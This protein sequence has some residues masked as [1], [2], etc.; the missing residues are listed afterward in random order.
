[1]KIAF[2]GG[3]VMA[4]AIIQRAIQTGTLNATDIC[5]VDPVAERRLLFRESLGILITS[6][7]V[8]DL[9]EFPLI[10]VAV[11][12]QQ[13]TTVF[14][15]TRG[16]LSDDHT[17]LSI[18]AGA[19]I[20][21]LSRGFDLP[22]I[23]RVMPNTPSQIGLGVSVW[24]A[25]REVS[26]A[27]RSEATGLLETLGTQ[28]YV[29]NENYLDM[30]TAI[31]GSGPAY[32]FLFMECL[33][34]SAVAMGI[35]RPIASVLVTET[36]LGSATLAKFSQT[37]LSGLR[38]MVTSKGGTTESA[39]RVLDDRNFRETIDSAIKKAHEKAKALN[40]RSSEH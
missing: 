7:T 4:E 11:K 27:F 26:M 3:G 35:P 37:E 18:V 22:N 24:T 20:E 10:V 31:S 33:L 1:M 25:T 6:E 36:V 17:V 9:R 21:T 39:L 2:I 38:E 23:I 5:V 28:I 29:E 8:P 15:A 16:K 32:V 14:N 40:T 34:D 30:A 19:S 12:P 13:L